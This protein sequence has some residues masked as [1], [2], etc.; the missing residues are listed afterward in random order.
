M[1]SAPGPPLA[2]GAPAGAAIV[3]AAPG[4]TCDR[5][6]AFPEYDADDGQWVVQANC[7]S[8]SGSALDGNCSPYVFV[9]NKGFGG[10]LGGKAKC[11]GNFWGGGSATSCTVWGYGQCWNWGSSINSNRRTCSSWVVGIAWGTVTCGY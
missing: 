1:R 7:E 5:Q 11:G 2:C 3:D 10:G 8:A 4:S 9:F 6:V